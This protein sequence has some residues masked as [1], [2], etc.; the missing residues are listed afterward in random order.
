MQGISY[1]LGFPHVSAQAGRARYRRD[2]RQPLAL[3]PPP[4]LF[5]R[6]P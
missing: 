5:P 4:L 1:L 2:T 3:A 6:G